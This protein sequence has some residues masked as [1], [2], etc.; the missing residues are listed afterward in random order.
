MATKIINVSDLKA[1]LA[2][3]LAELD[4]DGVPFYVIQHGKPKAVLVRYDEY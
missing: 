3:L 2:R 1:R 4:E